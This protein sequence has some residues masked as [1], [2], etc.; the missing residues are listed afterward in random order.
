MAYFSPILFIL[1]VG[2]EA[3]SAW[4]SS[5]VDLAFL[6]P[7]IQICRSQF[8]LHREDKAMHN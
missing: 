6:C 5:A 3:L 1:M 4:T 2:L 8:G 7:L